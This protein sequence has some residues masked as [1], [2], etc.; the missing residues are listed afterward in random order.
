VPVWLWVSD[1]QPRSESASAAGVTATVTAAPTQVRWDTGDDHVTIC[2][3]PGTPYDATRPPA[4]QS[5]TCSHTYTGTTGRLRVTAAQSWHLTYV[6]TNGQ[7]GDL[8]VVT[9]TSTLPIE[10]R[11]LVTNIRPG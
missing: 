7:S 8:G 3:G 6:A 4:A 2:R 9:R 10:V 11:E 5:T 1:W